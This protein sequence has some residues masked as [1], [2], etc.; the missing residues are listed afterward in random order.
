MQAHARHYFHSPIGTLR[1]IFLGALA[2]S[3]IAVPLAAQSAPPAPSQSA[4]EIAAGGHMQFDVASIKRN[5]GGDAAPRGSNIPLGPMDAFTPTGGLL[6]STNIPLLQYI[7][8]AY[9]PTSTQVQSI[10]SQLPK[11]ANTE[12]FDIEAHAS[13]NPTKDQFRLMMQSLLADRFKLKLH[14][15]TKQIPVLALALDKPG[16]LGPKIQ[17]HPADAPPCSTAAAPGAT[18]DGGFP[19]QCGVINPSFSSGELKVGARNVPLTML[20]N[21]MGSQQIININRPVVNKTG[22]DANVDFILGFTPDA[23]PGGD[24]RADSSGPTFLE[25]LKDQLGMKLEQTTAPVDSIV[26]DHIEEPSEN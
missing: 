16:K 25:A 13:G 18:V 15:E 14:Y 12:Y 23:P 6:Q 4:W 22:I 11:W 19:L 24:P 2:A 26:V 9:K 10:Q 20:T 3:A 7:V 21:L 17:L 1:T 8:F 5:L